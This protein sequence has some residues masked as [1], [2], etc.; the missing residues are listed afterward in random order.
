MVG[1][2]I[3]FREDALREKAKEVGAIWRPCQKLWEMPLQT[4]RRLGLGSRIVSGGPAH[5]VA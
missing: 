2:K 5:P 4:A 1:V 3:F